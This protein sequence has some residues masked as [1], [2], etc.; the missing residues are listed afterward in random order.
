M[1]QFS[2]FTSIWLCIHHTVSEYC[3]DGFPHSEIHESM[4][5]C[6][7]SWLIAACHV[8][9]R[10]LMPRHSSYALISLTSSAQVSLCSFLLLQKFALFTVPPLPKNQQIFGSPWLSLA[11]LVPE[12]RRF[13]KPTTFVLC[14]PNFKRSLV[15]LEFLLNYMSKSCKVFRYQCVFNTF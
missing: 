14:H 9:L 5:I 10:L 7:S 1:F 13:L 6:S 2:G 12:I 15:L 4:D 11:S 3:S 8:L